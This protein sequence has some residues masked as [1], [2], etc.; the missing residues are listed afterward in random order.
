MPSATIQISIRLSLCIS[1]RSHSCFNMHTL[2]SPPHSCSQSATRRE[3]HTTVMQFLQHR[4]RMH[5][6][7]FILRFLLLLLIRLLLIFRG[8]RVGGQGL[9]PHRSLCMHGAGI[10]TG[11][12]RRW[13]EEPLHEYRRRCVCKCACVCVHVP[14][15]TSLGQTKSQVPVLV[16][17]HIILPPPFLWLLL[18][19]TCLLLPAHVLLN[20]EILLVTAPLPHLSCDLLFLPILLLLILVVI[21]A[22]NRF[23]ASITTQHLI[24][25]ATQITKR[26]QS[27]V[28]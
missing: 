7:S 23:A 21:P 13:G 18:F 27:R 6:F 25:K 9:I 24:T 26:T 4:Q 3:G 12:A 8:G 28:R 22:S 19:H 2:S 16:H 1:L 15:P 10:R 11:S 17:H 14:L 5:T 20:T